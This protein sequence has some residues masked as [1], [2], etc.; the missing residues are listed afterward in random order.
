MTRA[1]LESADCLTSADSCLQGFFKT[2]GLAIP[3]FKN[4]MV[5]DKQM[6]WN[7]CSPQ[8]DSI[9]SRVFHFLVILSGFI[10]C[11]FL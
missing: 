4:A 9:Q 7:F 5:E 2:R 6:T 3:F 11:A 8:T 1:R 10:L